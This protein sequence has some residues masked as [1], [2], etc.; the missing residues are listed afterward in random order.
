MNNQFAG[1]SDADRWSRYL[2]ALEALGNYGALG[3]T[4][5]FSVDGY[6]RARDFKAS[7][8]L[9]NISLLLANIELRIL[10]VTDRNKAIN[11][12]LIV[13]PAIVDELDALLFSNLEFKY[14]GN[15]YK[16]QRS[17]LVRLGRY[18]SRNLHLEEPAAYR[19]GIEQ[20]K[21]SFD[22]LTECLSKNRRLRDDA[23]IGVANSSS[24]GN[25]GIQDSGLA[26]TRSE[27]YRSADFIFSGRPK[28]REFFLGKSDSDTPKDVREKYGS[29]KP[30]VHGC[31]AH[32]L[33]KIGKPDLDRYTWIRADTTFEGLRQIVFEPEARVFIGTSSPPSPI[34]RVKSVRLTFP[35]S[36]TLKLDGSES[37]FCFSGDTE[38]AF[39]SGLTCLIGGRGAGKST[40]VNLIAERLNPGASDFLKH[41]Q[42]REN[43]QTL[44]V[45]SCVTP[46]LSGDNSTVEFI[47]QNEVEHFALNPA[48]LTE[49]IYARL[50]SIDDTGRLVS[51]EQLALSN[52]ATADVRLDLLRQRTALLT[53]QLDASNR[54]TALTTLL[55]S[56]QD[57]VFVQTTTQ[58]RDLAGR[59]SDLSSSRLQLLETLVGVEQVLETAP[60]DDARAQNL[61]SEALK[62]FRST[63]QAAI[64]AARD[65]RDL[66][67]A[68]QE[69]S[70]L[71]EQT[72][73]LRE[74]LNA[75]LGTRGLSA[76]NLR[77]VASAGQQLSEVETLLRQVGAEIDRVN[78][79][80][81]VTD[82]SLV[83]RQDFEVEVAALVKKVNESFSADHAEVKR[84][85]LRYRFDTEAAAD[86]AVDWLQ[87]EIGK[88]FPAA[89]VRSDY[90]R[91]VLDRTG[92]LL[93]CSRHVLLETVRND[94]SK[95][96]QT[97]DAF[98][99]TEPNL[100]VWDTVRR[101]CNANVGLFKRLDVLYDGKPL[102]QASF[103]QRCSA[104]LI[105][106]I[107][108]GNTPIIIDEPEAHLDSALIAD[109]LVEMVKRVKQHRQIIFATHNA[110][111]VVNG[112]AELVHILS[113]EGDR[114]SVRSATLEDL[115][116]RPSI[117][118][119]EGGE[120]AFRQREG[121]YRL[122]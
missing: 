58:I 38:L 5:Y 7:G 35:A 40:L 10:P 25:S 39:A 85:E 70:Q 53:R 115:S 94:E 62:S 42:L 60:L 110:N 89:R 91:S 18:H 65:G 96:A 119:L 82:V 109:F 41:R 99:G 107:S 17:E 117:L 24:D 106:L 100:E 63:V 45:S 3:I 84:L 27:I 111:F 97:I 50:R 72:A 102:A 76:E 52:V 90:L 87:S 33:E 92:D 30:C 28:D 8:R 103:G 88:V 79:A 113:M 2:D 21:V 73:T 80:L 74:S 4:D 86:A 120:R 15:T 32:E 77:D 31:D 105:V 44:K 68:G 98:L 1:E 36:T 118:S 95:N 49:A 93:G 83:P 47:P 57:P 116:E 104:V 121:R 55:T 67:L 122:G 54:A 112:D 9:S 46:D 81:S 34:H 61:Y 43:N 20:F 48:K 16:C 66:S 108:L 13:S 56:F 75:F 22:Q 29:L 78:G 19:I 114:T 6:L 14:D 51:T 71:A 69:E 26:A 64:L 12:H 59:Q 11:V 37:E 101:R 23:L